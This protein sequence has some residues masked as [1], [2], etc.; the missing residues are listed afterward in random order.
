MEKREKIVAACIVGMLA[1]N[2]C[3]L[4]Q[5]QKDVD[6]LQYS[7]QNEIQR[8]RDDVRSVDGA[9]SGQENRIEELLTKQASLFSQTSIR[10]TLQGKQLA[11]TMQGI[12]KELKNNETL[13]ARITAN[14]KTYE[15]TTDANH[16]ATLLIDPMESF[17]PSFIIKSANGV[18][19]E[20][21]NE[22]YPLDYLAI[23]IGCGWKEPTQ[24][25]PEG[26]PVLDIYLTPQK[27]TIPLQADDI[28]KV[29]CIVVNTGIVDGRSSVPPEEAAPEPVR[30]FPHESDETAFPEGDIVPAVKIND[31]DY[32]HYQADFT[33]YTEHKD[34]IQYEIHLLVTT[35]NGMTFRSKYNYIA[36]FSYNKDGSSASSGSGELYPVFE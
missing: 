11:V 2:S 22:E 13:I 21:L 30:E 36:D 33:S 34:G 6:H 3:Q 7:T 32:L 14:G 10:Y 19:Q 24:E 28:A 31:G 12:P 20:A 26:Q 27:S 15:Q 8:L 25:Y 16:Q 4:Y 17:Q 1:L 35:K 5:L 29:E 18:R 23:P 9:V